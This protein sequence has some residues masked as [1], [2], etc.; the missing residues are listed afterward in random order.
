MR[1]VDVVIGHVKLI[2]RC[3]GHIGLMP[4]LKK[5]IFDQRAS[6]SAELMVKGLFTYMETSTQ[7]RHTKEADK[8]LLIDLKL[9]TSAYS[10]TTFLLCKSFTGSNVAEMIPNLD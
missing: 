2:H 6:L 7:N 10:Y 5:I 4:T 3:V 8:R 9:E 1:N